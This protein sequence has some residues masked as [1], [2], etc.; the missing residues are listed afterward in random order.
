MRGTLSYM[1]PEQIAGRETDPRTDFFAFACVLYEM[2]TGRSAFGG[3]TESSIISAL[4][5]SEPPAPGALQPLVPAALDRLVMTGLAKDPDERWTSARL[6]ADQLRVIAQ[7]GAASVGWRASISSRLLVAVTVV[8]VLGALVA[9]EGRRVL[10]PTL[11]VPR[12]FVLP[13]PEGVTLGAVQG[14]EFS[15]DGKAIIYWGTDKGVPTLFWHN[16]NEPDARAIFGTDS[17][18]QPL[19]PF[20]SP[21][22]AWLGFVRGDKLMKIAIR[23]EQIAEGSSPVALASGIGAMRGVSWGD[24]GTIVYCPNPYAGLWRVAA[25]G[26]AAREVTRPDPS[27]LENGHCW[28]QVLPGGRSALFTIKHASGRQDKSAIAVVALDTG[29]VTRLIEG[30]SYARYA[31]GGYIVYARNGSLLAVPF[32]LRSLTVTGRPVAVLSGVSMASAGTGSAEFAISRTGALVYGP[33]RPRPTARNS[34]VWVDRDGRVDPVTPETRSYLST[35]S[36]SPDGKTLVVRIEDARRLDSQLW[37]YGLADHHWQQLTSEGDNAAPSWSPAGNRIAFSSNRDG[38]FNLYLMPANGE[39]GAERLTRSP[40]WQYP[41]SWSPDGRLLAYQEQEEMF[42]W[43]IWILPLDGDRRPWRWGPVNVSASAA[44]FAPRGRWIAYE[45]RE[46]GRSEVYVRPSSGSGPAHRVSG[47]N[48]GRLPLWSRDGRSLLYLD[49]ATVM[50]ASVESDEP[51]RLTTPH[52]AFVLP[53]DPRQLA[54]PR[55]LTLTPDGRRIVLV[56]PDPE[57]PQARRL[58][59]IPNWIE[60]LK[61]KVRPAP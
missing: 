58:L 54:S 11:P 17:S 59:I 57:P 1:A 43:N 20:V 7:P 16:L 56:R 25:E 55:A 47:P 51:L 36:L 53:F 9:W 19:S 2:L 37:A 22:G 50:A 10:A 23:S 28:P 38:P 46:S 40:H 27:K 18:D 61:A 60:E 34:L 30:G 13:P 5:S 21:D 26:G 52:L 15:S 31:P 24:D 6:V 45:S 44:M 48:G 41:C 8:S 39:G 35:M 12:T 14:V 49:G 42:G 32:D 29:R 33:A 4:M 3:D